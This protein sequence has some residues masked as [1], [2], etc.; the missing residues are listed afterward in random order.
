MRARDS[1]SRAMAAGEA[2]ALEQSIAKWGELLR[3]GSVL[4]SAGALRGPAALP[5]LRGW[6]ERRVEKAYES[7]LRSSLGSGLVKPGATKGVPARRLLHVRAE[8]ST[9]ELMERVGDQQAKFYAA[10]Q[11]GL[12]GRGHL[13]LTEEDL[14]GL[15]D[16]QKSVWASTFGS[17]AVWQK[18]KYKVPVGMDAMNKIGS[19]C[20]NAATR[21]RMFEAYHEG[22]GT[23]ADEAALELLR[24]RR[25]LARQLGFRTWADFELAPMA[26]SDEASARRLMDRCWQDAKPALS[27]VMRRM[28]EL[29]SHHDGTGATPAS[30]SRTS[31]RG[32]GA[33]P[34]SSKMSQVDEA[35]YRALI[36]R[37]ADTW[38]LAQ[39]LPAE[40]ILPSLLDVVGRAY[41]VHF[42]EVEPPQTGIRLLNGW[43]KSVRIYEVSDG[44][45][46]SSGVRSSGE[47][48]GKLG[49]VYMNLYQRTSLLGRP[50]VDLAGAQ[51]LCPGHAL[52]S[53][54]LVA[55]SMGQGKLL[56]PEEVVAISHELGHAVHMLCHT[57][58]PQ[59]FEDLPLDVLELPSTLLET[60]ALQPGTVSKYARH[61]SS[62][63]PPP[64]ELVRSCQ[65]DVHFFVRYLQSASVSL[66]L[67]GEAFDPSSASPSDLREA[68]AA[69]WQR[70]SVVPADPAFSPFGGDAGLYVAQGSNQIAYLLCYLRVEGILHG[71]SSQGGSRKDGIQRWQSPEFATR[72]R[73]QLLDRSFPGE[74]LAALW[75]TLSSGGSEEREGGKLVPPHPLPPP[76]ADTSVLFQR[77]AGNTIG[78]RA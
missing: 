48:R 45:P 63:G 67:H 51:L 5:F 30:S 15:K 8:A 68:S 52:L 31:T 70:Y 73:T 61:W 71:K 9:S 33:T 65:R 19:F 66:G 64:D 11:K 78:A 58:S 53:M 34:L 75:P 40:K 6:L 26:A 25:Q 35:F 50:Q 46:A 36:T 21:R 17:A 2:A 18:T 49:F 60:I 22:F 1:V 3:L 59:E 43:H 72:L 55:P 24:T 62:S 74:R 13:N 29:R 57:G 23:E 20:Q 42:R 7:A 44:P 76:P 16:N 69:L 41:S 27:A 39:F 10:L 77:A 38:R 32:P 56:N 4:S 28:D 47:N 14:V 54:N 37:E 12:G